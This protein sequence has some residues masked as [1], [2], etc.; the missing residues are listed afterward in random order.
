MSTK[1]PEPRPIRGAIFASEQVENSARRLGSAQRYLASYFI[2]P[3][4]AARPLL[5]TR[6][7]IDDAARLA[8]RN[9]EDIGV[10]AGHLP[11]EPVKPYVRDLWLVPAMCVTST[12]FGLLV[13]YAIWGAL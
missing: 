1:T 5:F 2:E 11:P 9:P 4:R 10:Y 13:G 12:A 6:H 8:D 7:V 3:G